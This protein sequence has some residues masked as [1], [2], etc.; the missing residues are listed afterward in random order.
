MPIRARDAPNTRAIESRGVMRARLPARAA[1]AQC[2]APLGMRCA[3]TR[4][5]LRQ[6]T[7][8][9]T[10][11]ACRIPAY[12]TTPLPDGPAVPDRVRGLAPRPI[13]TPERHD[14]DRGPAAEG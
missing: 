12:A 5:T 14:A 11:V 8:P 4:C 7:R 2:R 1:M 3:A 13:R 6:M 10:V 9:A